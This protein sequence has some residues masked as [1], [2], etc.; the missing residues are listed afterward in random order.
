MEESEMSQGNSG[1]LSIDESI[2]TS[3]L[4]TPKMTPRSPF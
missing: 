1:Y 2:V 3:M 4:T